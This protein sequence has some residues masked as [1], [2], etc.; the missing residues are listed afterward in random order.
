[1]GTLI[2]SGVPILQ[3]LETVAATAGNM[4]ISEAVLGARESV[5]EG[6]H[7]SDPLKRSG[8]FPNMVTAMISVGEETGALDAMLS[9]I[10]DFYDQEVDTAIK[11]LTSLIEPIVIVIM[12]VIVGTIV[13]AMF[14]PM[15]GMGEL[16]SN[17]EGK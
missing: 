14:L 11:G 12:G 15:F 3:A 4:V 8:V 2:K 6:G 5:R 17:M 16:A 13:A 7:L 10:A 1:L 9:K